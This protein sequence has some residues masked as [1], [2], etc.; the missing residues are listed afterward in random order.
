MRRQNQQKQAMAPL[1][2]FHYQQDSSLVDIVQ[3][4]PVIGKP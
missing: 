2:L 1:T 4:E 3:F